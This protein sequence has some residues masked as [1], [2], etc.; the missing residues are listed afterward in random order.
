MASGQHGFDYEFRGASL[1][2]R[3]PDT[4]IEVRY[5]DPLHGRELTPSYRIWRSL[6]DSDGVL[7]YPPGRAAVLIKVW[8]LGG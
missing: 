5:W 3:F 6:V 1:I 4:R 2:G 8:A 7:E